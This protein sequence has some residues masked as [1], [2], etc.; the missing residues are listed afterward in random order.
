MVGKEENGQPY[1]LTSCFP[2]LFTP[3]HNPPISFLDKRKKGVGT[4]EEEKME[5]GVKGG[6]P[7]LHHSACWVTFHPDPSGV[8]GTENREEVGRREVGSTP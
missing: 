5:H 1:L 4:S 3:V 8:R 7:F 6:A 2:F